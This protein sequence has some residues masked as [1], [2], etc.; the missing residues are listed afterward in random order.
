M[1]DDF[2]LQHR[3]IRARADALW[4]VAGSTPGNAEAFWFQARDAISPEEAALDRTAGDSFPAS[5]PTA[6]TASIGAT[7]A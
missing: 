3:R 6:F 5:D 1:T 4:E 7:K 2:D